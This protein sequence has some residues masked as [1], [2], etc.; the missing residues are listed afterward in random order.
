MTFDMKKM[1]LA[2]GATCVLAAC[3]GGS[4]DAPKAAAA[5]ADGGKAGPVELTISC[6]SVGQDFEMCKKLTDA[7]SQ[8]TGNKVKL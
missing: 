2:V 3:G 1:V 4:K 8:K 7:W 5:P 6:G